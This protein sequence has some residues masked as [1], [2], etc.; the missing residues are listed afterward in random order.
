MQIYLAA[1]NS[2][3]GNNILL[4]I[5]WVCNIIGSGTVITLSRGPIFQ[6]FIKSSYSSIPIEAISLSH[7]FQ[8]TTKNPISLSDCTRKT[9]HFENGLEIQG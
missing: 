4:V 5:G 3:I 6:S 7:S 8:Y 2:M 1:K 9:L